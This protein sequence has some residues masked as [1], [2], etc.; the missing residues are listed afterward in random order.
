MDQVKVKVTWGRFWVLPFDG[1]RKRVFWT[2]T[3]IFINGRQMIYEGAAPI[4]SA[5]QTSA[6]LPTPTPLETMDAEVTPTNRRVKIEAK[7]HAQ[8]Y[9]LEAGTEVIL[10]ADRGDDKGRYPNYPAYIICEVVD[11]PDNPDR[12]LGDEYSKLGPV[13]VKRVEF[14]E[15]L[16][17]VPPMLPSAEGDLPVVVG[18]FSPLPVKKD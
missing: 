18:P 17:F 5:L 16:W 15:S 4:D 1:P 8:T 6:A 9:L 11:E 3:A 10:W 14:R 13:R 12:F 7:L 2:D